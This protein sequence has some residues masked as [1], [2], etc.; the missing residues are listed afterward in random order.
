MRLISS[1]VLIALVAVSCKKNDPTIK[2]NLPL[3]DGMMVLCEGLYQQNN[4]TLSFVN[5]NTNQALNNFFFKSISE[6]SG[7]N[8]GA[9]MPGRST[10]AAYKKVSVSITRLRL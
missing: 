10:N 9:S 1:L 4:S 2:D 3:H 6:Q 8:T 7:T 5:F